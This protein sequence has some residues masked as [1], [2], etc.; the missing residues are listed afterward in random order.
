[1]YIVTDLKTIYV[2]KAEKTVLL[3]FKKKIKAKIDF[4]EK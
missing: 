1:M 2:L 4:K 3:R